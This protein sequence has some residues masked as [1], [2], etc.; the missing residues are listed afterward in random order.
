MSVIVTTPEKFPALLRKT[1]REDIPQ[2]QA[3]MH[4]KIHVQVSNG[5]IKG[6]PV[7]NPEL[8][9]IYWETGGNLPAYLDG[10]VGGRARGNWQSSIGV[11]TAGETGRVDK[12][13]AETKA[14]NRAAVSKVPPFNRSFI[15]NNVPYIVVLNDGLN[16]KQ[17]TFQAPLQWMEGH[18][19]LVAA[20]FQRDEI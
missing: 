7:G 8:W 14:A 17:H 1:M 20:Q 11:P 15:T 16:G 18:L 9:D 5:M 4:K 12:S 3:A 2:W 19:D 13:G 10:Y 6:T